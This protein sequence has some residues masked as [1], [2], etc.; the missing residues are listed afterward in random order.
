MT[1]IRF[2]PLKDITERF[3][4]SMTVAI[5]RVLDSGWYLHGPEVEAFERE[6]AEYIGCL[7]CVGVGNGLDALTLSLM[8]MKEYYNW[9]ADAEVIVPGLTFIAT[10]EAVVR[11]G[12]TPVFADVDENALLTVETV[13]RVHTP[14]TKAVIPVHL[15]GK[16]ADMVSLMK[17]AR[18]SQLRVLEDAAQAHGAKID[19]RKVGQ[20]G[21]MA[22]FSFYPG[23]NLGA[24]GDAGAVTTDNADLAHLVAVLSNYGAERKYYHSYLGLNSRLDELQAAV[25]RLKL[26]KLDADNSR[27][28]QL[29]KNYARLINNPLVKIPYNGDIEGSVFH[30]YALRCGLRD[31]LQKH[32][33]EHGVE[34][35]IHYPL[36]LSE[37]QALAPY[38][39]DSNHLLNNSLA[40]AHSELSIPMSPLLTD[41]EVEIIAAAINAFEQ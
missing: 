33:F 1:M 15:Y 12:L 35:L 4:A 27:R 41:E 10:A 8:A 9:P 5:Q 2:L 37:Q 28:V 26:Q 38:F 23:K 31:K 6:F 13:S 20:W 34:T 32:L 18:S 39:K 19:G 25:L 21:E 29:A 16:A 3:G 22:A 36:A 40:W 17:W 11:A 14:N 7:H 24:L 30:I